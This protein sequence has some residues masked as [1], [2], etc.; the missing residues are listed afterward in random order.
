MALRILGSSGSLPGPDNPASG[1]LLECTEVHTGVGDCE[2]SRE[3]DQALSTSGLILDIGGGVLGALQKQ[4]V[5]PADYH[6]ALS[7]LHA[8]HCS[9]F[10]SLL[11]WRR[12][13]P[14]LSATRSHM[15]C[16]P[17]GTP[18]LVA[19]DD[20]SDTFTFHAMNPDEP[21]RFDN[22]FELRV[23]PAVHPVEAY[24]MRITTPQGVLAYSG[25]SGPA[26]SLIECARGA[27]YFLCEATWGRSSAG[28]PANMHLSGAEAGA[29][30]AA[31]GVKHF[32]ITHIPPWV[33][34]QDAYEAA[35]AEFSGE[36]T[37]VQ[38]GD[39][40]AFS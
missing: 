30:A 24:S 19:P 8:D 40:Y 14:T 1:Y 7:H 29:I 9:D 37:L 27:D 28:K 21:I 6:V 15:L 11:V 23:F 34:S 33:N 32:L 12:Y 18:G 36:I 13:H 38:A 39:T 31:A 22:G 25:D 2:S 17:S 20:F 35:K 10:A 26:D 5:N 4:G 16:G 3:G